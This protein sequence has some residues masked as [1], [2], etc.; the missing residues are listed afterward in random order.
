[1]ASRSDD[2]VAIVLFAIGFFGLRHLIKSSSSSQNVEKMSVTNFV[3]APGIT[4]S[5]STI[6]C[7][8]NVDTETCRSACNSDS[9]CVAYSADGPTSANGN[10]KQ[11]CTYSKLDN[12]VAAAYSTLFSPSGGTIKNP[13]V[14]GW[15]I[16]PSTDLGG[17]DIACY[18]GVNQSKAQAQCATDP[19]CKAYVYVAPSAGG[20]WATGG[21]CLKNTTS[22]SSQNNN[23]TLWTKPS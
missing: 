4:Q 1:M 3:A 18:T 2:K 22:G 12:I 15:N 20:N 11:C 16:S 21:A 17:S 6:K 14:M 5:G 7:Y 23:V 19:N 13:G 8:P 9:T 10:Q